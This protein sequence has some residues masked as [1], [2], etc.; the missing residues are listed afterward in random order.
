[1]RESLS[2][3]PNPSREAQGASQLRDPFPIQLL[4]H[5]GKKMSTVDAGEG[6]GSRSDCRGDNKKRKTIVFLLHSPRERKK[7]S[8]AQAA[9]SHRETQGI[10]FELAEGTPPPVSHTT[11]SAG[12]VL[13]QEARPALALQAPLWVP[14]QYFPLGN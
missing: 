8:K 3:A 5:R 1:M 6:R 4:R 7:T 12:S 14:A 9:V 10:W 13:S 11:P 2:L